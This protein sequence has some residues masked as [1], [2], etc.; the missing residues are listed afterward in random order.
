M[1]QPVNLD[2]NSIYL[3]SWDRAIEKLTLAHLIRDFAAFVFW[4][5]KVRECDDATEPYPEPVESIPRPSTI[6]YLTR[7]L[8]VQPTKCCEHFRLSHATFTVLF[9]C[10]GAQFV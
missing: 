7:S 1:L 6:R 5:R 10:F 4:N 3:S 2:H 8:V 9:N